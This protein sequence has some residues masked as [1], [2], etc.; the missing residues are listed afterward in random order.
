M[1]NLRFDGEKGL[2]SLVAFASAAFC[3]LGMGFLVY[4]MHHV[5]PRKGV[6][7]GGAMEHGF[8]PWPASASVLRDFDID[9]F[10]LALLSLGQTDLQDPVL[11]T[12]SINI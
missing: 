9:L 8:T 12:R 5:P 11:H 1:E 4:G 6:C 3:S 10:R 7:S 2:G